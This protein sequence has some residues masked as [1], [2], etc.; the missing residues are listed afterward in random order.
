MGILDKILRRKT[1]QPRE[2][3]SWTERGMDVQTDDEKAAT[4]SR[5]EA[6]MQA[7][8]DARDDAAKDAQ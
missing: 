3:S 1:E 8:R 5:M 6:E 4:R 7:G 2:K